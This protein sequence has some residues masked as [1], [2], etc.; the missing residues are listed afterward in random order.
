M[1]GD[2]PVRITLSAFMTILTDYFNITYR[3]R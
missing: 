1:K 2:F 3:A